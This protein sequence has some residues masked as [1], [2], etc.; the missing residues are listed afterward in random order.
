MKPDCNGTS[1]ASVRR[2]RGLYGEISRKLCIDRSLVISVAIGERRS[3]DVEDALEQGL[4]QI[5]E[6]MER[7]PVNSHPGKTQRVRRVIVLDRVRGG[8]ETGTTRAMSAEN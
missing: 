5:S 3:K 4:R 1:R 7:G 6:R 8:R 2:L